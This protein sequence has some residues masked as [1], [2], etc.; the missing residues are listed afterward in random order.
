MVFRCKDSV[1]DFLK[2][3]GYSLPSL[4][5]FSSHF[6]FLVLAYKVTKTLRNSLFT[7]LFLNFRLACL[8]LQNAKTEHMEMK[9]SQQIF[10]ILV[11]LTKNEVT[12]ICNEPVI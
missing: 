4:M 10:G 8:A 9:I 3:V 12:K 6:H 7:F 1:K 5:S 11:L 2:E